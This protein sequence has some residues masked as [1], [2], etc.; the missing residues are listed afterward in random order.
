M[1]K[2]KID[3]IE[4]VKKKYVRIALET[5][6]YSSTAKSAGICV[7][8]L[9]NWIKEYETEVR[10]EME[11]E[12][13]KL[14]DGEWTTQDYKERFEEAMSLLGKKELELAILRDELKKKS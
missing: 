3:V 2:R 5:M 10:D 9:R 4:N 1:A 11:R 12:G 13:V 6:Q 8:T 14:L 7:D